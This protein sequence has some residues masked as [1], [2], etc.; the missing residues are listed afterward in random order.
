M[1]LYVSRLF[2]IFYLFGAKIRNA[3][4]FVCISGCFLRRLLKITCQDLFFL[5][6][7][8]YCLCCLIKSSRQSSPDLIKCSFP[9]FVRQYVQCFCKVYPPQRAG[10][11]QGDASIA[12]RR[13]RCVSTSKK[14]Y[15][16]IGPKP[17]LF[18][19]KDTDEILKNQSTD[20]MF[21]SL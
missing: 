13:K 18:F 16:S 4:E 12:G 19:S 8:L 9:Y 2:F 17:L 6:V 5:R 21:A 11:R 10:Q 20:A 7:S 3:N 1:P 14:T 15:A